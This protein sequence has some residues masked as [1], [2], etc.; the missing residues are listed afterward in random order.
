MNV[1]IEVVV[2]LAAV[3]LAMGVIGFIRS[4]RADDPEMDSVW[5]ALGPV[6]WLMRSTR[7]PPG[8]GSGTRRP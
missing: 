7:R 6:G 4:H 1:A 5:M 3:A 8:S 2:A